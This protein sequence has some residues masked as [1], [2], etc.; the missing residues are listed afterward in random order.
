MVFLV[1]RGAVIWRFGFFFG[2]LEERVLW[3]SCSR[4]FSFRL[5][6]F[7][8]SVWYR[9]LRIIFL[10]LFVFGLFFVIWLVLRIRVFIF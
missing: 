5:G 2:F 8:F 10:D 3:D 7:Y 1:L 6:C 4:D 9:F